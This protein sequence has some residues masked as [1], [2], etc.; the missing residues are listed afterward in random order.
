MLTTREVC[1]IAQLARL[2]LSQAKLKLYQKQ[3]SRVLD[4][5][6]KLNELNTSK[7]KPT[8]H[9]TPITNRFRGK[10]YKSQTLSQESALKNA[11][12]KQRGYIVTKGVFEK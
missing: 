5:V 11:G 9:P 12:E 6:N 1:K 8:L 3:L 4:Y 2:D 7:V 10:D